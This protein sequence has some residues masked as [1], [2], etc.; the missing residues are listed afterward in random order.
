MALSHQIFLLR[1]FRE[2]CWRILDRSLRDFY[3]WV[4]LTVIFLSGWKIKPVCVWDLGHVVVDIAQN[5][6]RQ[7]LAFY[8]IWNNV[9]IGAFET[10]DQPFIVKNKIGQISMIFKIYWTVFFFLIILIIFKFIPF[11][12]NYGKP[13][14]KRIFSSGR[15]SIFIYLRKKLFKALKFGLYILNGKVSIKNV[16]ILIKCYFFLHRSFIFFDINV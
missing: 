3:P 7:I 16:W 13:Y 8:L 9:P 12:K 15:N 11:S 6:L 4:V 5:H 2:A 10:F 14:F 1:R